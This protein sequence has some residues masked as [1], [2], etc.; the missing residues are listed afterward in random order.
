MRCG[1]RPQQFAW[2]VAIGQEKSWLWIGCCST[3]GQVVAR[4]GWSL[5]VKL[6]IVHLPVIIPSCP[7]PGG[8]VLLL[9]RSLRD[10]HGSSAAVVTPFRDFLKKRSIQSANLCVCTHLASSQVLPC[11]SSPRSLLNPL[12][13]STTLKRGLREVLFLDSWEVSA[14]FW[15]T[16]SLVEQKDL[17]SSC[18]REMLG[19][20]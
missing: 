8:S 20:H 17:G 15:E 16:G 19:P 3:S 9:Q 5:E 4:S 7:Q 11:F 1:S 2:E 18:R 13:M 12:A 6:E 14:S 10:A